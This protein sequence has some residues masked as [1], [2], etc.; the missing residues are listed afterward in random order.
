[1]C[2]ELRALARPELYKNGKTRQ[3][4]KANKN[5]MTTAP[6]LSLIKTIR[7]HQSS[8]VFRFDEGET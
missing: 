3:S 5:S 7:Y 2:V 1:M 6:A 4:Q 8:D